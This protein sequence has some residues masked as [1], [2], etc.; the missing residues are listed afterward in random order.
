MSNYKSNVILHIGLFKSGSTFIQSHFRSVKLDDYKIYNL[1][2]LII[3]LYRGENSEDYYIE[4]TLLLHCKLKIKK[5]ARLFDF[6]GVFEFL[7]WVFG[8]YI[9]IPQIKSIVNTPLF[10]SLHCNYEKSK[11]KLVQ[12]S[13]DC[14]IE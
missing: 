13:E 1:C 14:Y 9:R 8:D 2:L 3:S 11:L 12:L 10:K 4:L 5:N 7:G 6:S